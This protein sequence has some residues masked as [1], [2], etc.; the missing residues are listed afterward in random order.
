MA[1]IWKQAAL[2]L[3]H[4]DSFVNHGWLADGSIDWID[5]A[6]PEEMEGIFAEKK[7]DAED[8]DNYN[9]VNKLEDDDNIEGE[10]EEVGEE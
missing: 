9:D 2:P 7:E 4:I 6:F 10:E 1:K 5:A 3:Q 8:D